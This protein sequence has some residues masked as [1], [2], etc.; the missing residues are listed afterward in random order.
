MKSESTISANQFSILILGTGLSIPKQMGRTLLGLRNSKKNSSLKHLGW[1]V[2]LTRVSQDTLA[3]FG[4][5]GDTPASTC[6]VLKS[7]V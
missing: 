5:I 1:E 7:K 3:W 6:Y 4:S 2:L